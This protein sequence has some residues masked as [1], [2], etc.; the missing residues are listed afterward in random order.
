MLANLADITSAFLQSAEEDGASDEM[1]DSAEGSVRSGWRGLRSG[2]R[3]ADS[4]GPD[5]GGNDPPAGGLWQ[6]S[7]EEGAER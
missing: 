1:E 5:D 7:G 2:W 6:G 4:V 3:M